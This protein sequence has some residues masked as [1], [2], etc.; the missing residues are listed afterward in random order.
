MS[1]LTKQDVIGAGSG[2]TEDPHRWAKWA[3]WL[4]AAA[5]CAVGLRDYRIDNDLSQWVPHLRAT[6]PVRSYAV[7]GFERNAIDERA[8]ADELCSLP[9]VSFCVDRHTVESGG[10]LVGVSPDEFVVGRDGTY[11]GIFLF[12]RAEINDQRFLAE[13]RR[14]L[15]D[16]PCNREECFNLGG[17][18]VF[19]IALNQAS[20]QRLP[21]IMLLLV[22]MI[23]AIALSKKKVP[24]EGFRPPCEP[25]GEIGKRVKPF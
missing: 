17:P 6:G 22:A 16:I 21:Y 7:V 2:S 23:G 18:A 10:H 9:T 3:V 14:A 8:L 20:Q 24:L 11:A 1:S 5:V 13:I 25:L 15:K 4:A 12:P 19:H